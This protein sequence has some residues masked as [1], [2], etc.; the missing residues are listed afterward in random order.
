ME[1]KIKAQ[2]SKLKINL[3][4]KAPIRPKL[5]SGPSCT[6]FEALIIGASLEL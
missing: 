3:K 5:N 1:T 2:I 4:P 6:G